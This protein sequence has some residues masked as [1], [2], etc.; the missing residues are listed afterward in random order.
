MDA[1]SLTREEGVNGIGTA[2]GK[3]GNAAAEVSIPFC[4]QSAKHVK[5]NLKWK[6][7]HVL[8]PKDTSITS[9]N[10]AKWSKK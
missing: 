2:W 6:I 8:G 10:V 1:P 9:W 5:S 7:L 3:S 4:R